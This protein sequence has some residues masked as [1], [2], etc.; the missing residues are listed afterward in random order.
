[1]VLL[2]ATLSLVCA[3]F[4]S[5]LAKDGDFRD[6]AYEDE[7]AGE[8]DYSDAD[9]AVPLKVTSNLPRRTQHR[10]NEQGGRYSDTTIS[11]DEFPD[12]DDSVYAAA[13]V[14]TSGFSDDPDSPP[15]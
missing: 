13:G 3:P 12:G 10:Y 14:S 9:E 2:A 15:C 11:F 1:M 8:S 6:Y 4:F 7:R 5:G